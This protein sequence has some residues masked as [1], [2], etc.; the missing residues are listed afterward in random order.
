M[1]DLHPA[2]P[3]LQ[4]FAEIVLPRHQ[5][6]L[7]PLGTKLQVWEYSCVGEY[8]I[9]FYKGKFLKYSLL[10]AALPRNWLDPK[11]LEY[12]YQ[13]YWVTLEILFNV[14]S[15]FTQNNTNKNL[16]SYTYNLHE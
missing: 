8:F 12:V 13:E 3:K 11:D 1:A 6:Y 7:Q 5:L 15:N 10:L 4:L 14:L 2:Q 16:F 9:K